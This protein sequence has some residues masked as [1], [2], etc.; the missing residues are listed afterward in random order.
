LFRLAAVALGLAPFVLV[1][2]LFVALDWGRPDLSSDPFVGFHG[3]R[4]LFV[5]NE[6]TDRYEIP[7]SR[8]AFF[9][10][11]S[12]TRRKGETEFR[13][14]CLGGSTVQGRPFAIQ[15]SFT[16]WLELSLRAAFPNREWQVVNCGGVSYASYRL[17]PILEEVLPYEPDLIIVYTGHNEFLEDRSYRNLKRLP[18]AIAEPYAWISATRSFNLLRQGYLRIREEDD[19]AIVKPTLRTEVDAMLDYRNGLADYHR[20]P[21]WRSGTIEHFRFNLRRMVAA[22]RDADVPLMLMNPV[23]QLRDCPPF[24]S[25]HADDLAAEQTERWESWVA[26]AVANR[27]VDRQGSLRLLLQALEIDDQHAGLQ[28]LLAACYDDLEMTEQAKQHYL[29]A[30]ENDICP[31]RMLEPM[32]AALREVARETGTPLVDVRAAIEARSPGGIP[33]EEHLLDHVHPTIETHKLIADWLLEQLVAWQGW[34]PE[35]GWQQARD[36][37][38]REHFAS[39][40]DLYFVQGTQRLEALRLWAQGRAEGEFGQTPATRQDAD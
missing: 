22:A 33:G 39:L 14:F 38:Y 4:P 17:A 25:Q 40:D 37:L 27:Q 29:R 20:D 16:T 5:L 32:H 6:D 18:T 7:A 24:K 13:I 35:T 10:P 26:E 36:D 23:C 2:F 31:L 12:F 28:Y 30:K 21:A 34:Q 3:T 11:D 15:T 19:Q 1:E 8:Q 9:C